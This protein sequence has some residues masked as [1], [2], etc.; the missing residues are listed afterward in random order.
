MNWVY[1]LIYIWMGYLTLRFVD[2][3]GG[4]DG[5]PMIPMAWPLVI[6]AGVIALAL[7][8]LI[9]PVA[10]LSDHLFKENE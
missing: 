2:R 1:L 10:W 3:D 7:Y 5:N 8:V 9:L 6:A 4:W